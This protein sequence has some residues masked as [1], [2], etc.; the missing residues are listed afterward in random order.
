MGDG[1]TYTSVVV[2]YCDE[3]YE[4]VG[5]SIRE[6]GPNAL[7]DSENPF[8]KP[9]C[10]EASFAP[11][12]RPRG[13]LLG[14]HEANEGSWPWVAFLD[15]DAPLHD[16]HGGICSGS[17]INEE[18]IITAAHCVTNKG[19]NRNTF[20][21]LI[22]STSVRVRLGLHRQSEP[23]EHVMERRVSEIIR[24]SSYNPVT[25]DNDIALLHVSEPVQF[26]EYVRPVCLPPTDL[27]TTSEFGM[28]FE[29]EIPRPPPDE[30]AIILGWGLT[31]NGGSR[32]DSLLE[33]YVPIV[34][35]EI[36]RDVYA[37]NG[38]DITASMLCAGYEE[39][40]RDACRGDSG[41]P[42]LFEDPNT[43]QYFVYGLVSWGR[44]G[45]C[46]SPDSYGVYARVSGHLYWIKDETAIHR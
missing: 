37:P 34:E 30:M 43:L 20:G 9:I 26:S 46:A 39:G 10:G 8:C 24:H 18:W 3:F 33:A 6:C 17:L 14:G 35:Q 38:W 4:L 2:Y 21:Q 36:C 15:I 27:I 22:E 44:P 28:E 1:F 40:G 7:W 19:T 12:D 5:P 41:G 25:F 32:A 11:R 13:R 45:E 29:D 31:S 42:L 23:S 16:I